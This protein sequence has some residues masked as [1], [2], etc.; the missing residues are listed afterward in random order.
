MTKEMC[1]EKQ[2][3][4]LDEIIDNAVGLPLESQRFLLILAKG[5]AFTRQCL[6]ASVQPEV[7]DCHKAD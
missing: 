4:V 1:S 5:M 3:S 6:S 2:D 7:P